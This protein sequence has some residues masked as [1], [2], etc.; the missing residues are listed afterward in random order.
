[1]AHGLL[2][3]AGL[4]S[5]KLRA[6]Y[7]AREGVLQRLAIWSAGSRD[8]TRP[9]LWLH[10]PSVGEGRQAESVLVR[11]RRRHPEW[12]VAY[13][14]FSASAEGLARRLGADVADYLPY[15]LPHAADAALRAL[16]PAALV[17]TKLDLWPELA[18]RAARQGVP[19]GLIAGTVRPGS[20]RL[21]W[22]ARALLAPGYAALDGA[23]AIADEDAERLIRLGVP[24]DRIRVLGDPR[25][26]SVMDRVQAVPPGDPLLR[27]GQG[28]PTMVAGSTW[29]GD[30]EVLL[31]AFARIRIH[32]G[33]ARLVIVPH[34]PTA[35]HLAAVERAAAGLG[36]PVPVRLSAADAPAPLLLVDRTGALATLYGAG[37]MA[38]VGGG[39]HRAGLHSVLEP[40][41]WGRPVVFG[42][43]WT[44]SRDA[45][46]LLTAGGAD[47]LPG[48][49]GAD[50]PPEALARLWED[51]IVNEP[52]RSAQGRRARRVV[53][54]GLGAAEA[55]ARFV[56]EMVERKQGSGLGTR[57]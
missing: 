9:L 39:F 53:E 48:F 57:D 1:M 41:A 45:A 36:L 15:D 35:S 27:L 22:P 29:P 37:S 6:G 25:F 13:T 40:A 18:T 24:R 56:E 21:R 3:A 42:P 52:H 44:E 17:F 51:W 12:Q 34:E 8:P 28:A 14:H 32:R 38:Y 16:S 43:R 31:Q 20:G 50:K 7:A 10:A 26:D 54:D 33:D 11:L 46:L 19:V 30:E 5:P 55:T 2:P 49:G 23:A 47:A 4:V